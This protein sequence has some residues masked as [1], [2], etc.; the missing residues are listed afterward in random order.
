M[1]TLGKI[2][3]KLSESS[4]IMI[5]SQY[6]V[7]KT[8][9]V[10][11]MHLDSRLLAAGDVF[12]A[13]PGKLQH[14]IDFAEQAM[15]K[16]IIAIL[17]NDDE[18]TREFVRTDLQNN[19]P[20]IQVKNFSENVASF[21]EWF[22]DYP[23]KSVEVIGVTGTN[24]KTSVTQFIANILNALGRD[25]GVIGTLGYG[26]SHDC[27]SHASYQ[28]PTTPD[29]I[30]VQRIFSKLVDGISFPGKKASIV[31]MEVSSHALDQER[32]STVVF[33]QAI[34]TNI[35]RDHLDY[36]HSF[37]AYLTAKTKLFTSKDLAVAVI[38]VDDDHADSFQNILGDNVTC[39]TYS[40]YQS[41][42]DVYAK[43]ITF[44]E[45]GI[46][47][48]IVTP[49]GEF[50]LSTT[51]LGRFNLSNLLAAVT[52]VSAKGHDIKLIEKSL[53]MLTSL[54]GRMQS[55][56]APNYP[57]IIID[58]AHTPH[59]LESALAAAKEHCQGKIWCVFGCGG[60]RDIGKRALMGEVAEKYADFL[61]V[62]DDNP[63]FESSSVI[64]DNI[65]KGIK[66]P[67]LV[68]VESDRE[69]AIAYAINSANV[70]DLVLVAGKGHENYQ[71]I[72]GEQYPFSD[73]VI[74]ESVMAAINP[75]QSL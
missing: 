44:S 14:G 43:N 29:A 24:G 60:S 27:L 71:E 67:S 34:F 21:A 15:D 3:E 37:D 40:T 1:K 64:I 5:N 50:V 32:L 35:S 11:D 70:T 2:F 39:Y 41:T 66:N 59:A 48:D 4:E 68:H 72:N 28:S 73:Q 6:S 12:C 62:T 22:F 17:A 55:I 38:N 31:A 74:V 52:S 47:A 19:I 61:V 58:Y 33:N 20:V 46:L 65:L 75:G 42:A 23:A 18:K 36:H 10:L 51:L 56:S 9:D 8:A 7:E 26:F 63:R 69:L 49:W 30:N 16:K 25:C 53:T 57:T 54:P 13:L 45:T